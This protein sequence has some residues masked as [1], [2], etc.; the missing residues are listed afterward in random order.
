MPT[1]VVTCRRCNEHEAVRVVRNPWNGRIRE[2]LCAPCI[3]E[4]TT[5]RVPDP[6]GA[7]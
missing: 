3:E 4:L 6:D 2:A 5:L 1:D 7:S